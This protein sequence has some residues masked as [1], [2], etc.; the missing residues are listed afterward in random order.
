MTVFI[1]K[2]WGFGIPCSPLQF[3]TE[4]WRARAR[5]ELKPGDLV[6]IVGTK[7]PRT[8]PAEQGRL[9]GIMEPTT[10]VVFWQDFD[11]PTR[12]EHF[13]TEGEYR[14]PFGLLNRAAWKIAD[15]DRRLL[16]DVTSREFHMDAALGIVPLSDEEAANVM[17]LAREPV[18]LLLPVRARARI[19]G[20]ESARRRAAPPPT[21]TRQGVMHLRRAPAYTYLM[22][23]ENAEGIAFKVGWA[24][25]YHIRQ[26][27]FNQAALPEI[28]GVRY[29]TR[30]DRLWDTARQAFAM[31]QAILRQFDDKRHRANREVLHGIAY[32]TLESAWIDYLGRSQRARRS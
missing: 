3:S 28:G 7:G 31:E 10:K 25:D 19:E 6:A 13:D 22:A 24:F 15:A 32:E 8:Q 11:L 23:I 9:L 21:T 4:G 2:T 20:E 12:P 30:L 14:W 29:R 17:Q 26:Q 1:T 16:E 5:T 18:E 27:Q